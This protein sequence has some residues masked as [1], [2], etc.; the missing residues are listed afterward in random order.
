LPS[1]V[2]QFGLGLGGDALGFRLG[3][4]D[5]LLGLALGAGAA[6]LV[7]VEHLGRLVLETAGVVDLDLDARAAMIER[8]QQG[9]V[10]PD[11]GEH[12]HQDDEGDRDPSFR[13]GEEHR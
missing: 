4:G 3:A 7:S 6:G 11:I 13:F 1:A 5:D 9:L 2:F 8:A 10:D 12:A